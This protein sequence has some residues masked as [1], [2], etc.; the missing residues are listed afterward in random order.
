MS[1]DS[2]GD[3]TLDDAGDS[4]PGT[5]LGFDVGALDA[6]LGPDDPSVSIPDTSDADASPALLRAF[7]GSVF[8]LKIGAI[9]ATLGLLFGFFQGRW[10]LAGLGVAIGL[11]AFANGYRQYRRYQNR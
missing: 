4:L 10:R 1:D 2:P 9:A 7:W 3:S 11:V 6:E 8:A 5:D